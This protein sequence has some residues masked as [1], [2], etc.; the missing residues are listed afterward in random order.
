M[1]YIKFY[2]TKEEAEKMMIMKN[3]SLTKKYFIKYFRVVIEGPD[4]NWAVVDYKTAYDI[5]A[6]YILKW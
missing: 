3:R 6:T 1:T 4:N 2:E 5:G